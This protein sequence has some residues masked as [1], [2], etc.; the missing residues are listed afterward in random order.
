VSKFD[1]DYT[2][3]GQIKTWTRQF[4]ASPSTFFG[5]G[6]DPVNQLLTASLTVL[7]PDKVL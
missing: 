6:Y 7:Y 5:L 4:D 2:A 3:N 1:Y